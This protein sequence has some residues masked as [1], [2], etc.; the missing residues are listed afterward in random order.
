M[1]PDS[2]DMITNAT[3]LAEKTRELRDLAAASGQELLAYLLD[4]AH[5]ESV[6]RLSEAKRSSAPSADN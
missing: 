5:D 2:A 6:A 4:I 3:Y 1:P